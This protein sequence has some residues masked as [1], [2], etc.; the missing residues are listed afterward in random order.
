M[1]PMSQYIYPSQEGNPLEIPKNIAVDLKEAILKKEPLLESMLSIQKEYKSNMKDM[2]LDGRF[3]VAFY[4]LLDDTRVFHNYSKELFENAQDIEIFS[5]ETKIFE[6]LKKSEKESIDIEILTAEFLKELKTEKKEKGILNKRLAELHAQKVIVESTEKKIE[7]VIRKRRRDDQILAHETGP[8]VRINPS[9]LTKL[10]LLMITALILPGS[11]AKREVPTITLHEKEEKKRDLVRDTLSKIEDRLNPQKII[12]TPKP[13]NELLPDDAEVIIIPKDVKLP[14]KKEGDRSSHEEKKRPVIK[15]KKRTEPEKKTE[16]A[17]KEVIKKSME[18][19]LAF[20]PLLMQSGIYNSEFIENLAKQFEK[21]N[22]EIFEEAMKDMIREG[23]ISVEQM[24]EIK[25]QMEKSAP[26][27]AQNVRKKMKQLIV[28]AEPELSSQQIK[29]A[30]EKYKR[31]LK[32]LYTELSFLSEKEKIEVIEKILTGI[33]KKKN[34]GLSEAFFYAQL[35]EE[36]VYFKHYHNMSQVVYS[37]LSKAHVDIPVTNSL[38]KLP[39]VWRNKKGD[40]HFLSEK[41]GENIA[42]GDGIIVRPGKKQQ[43]NDYRREDDRVKPSFVLPEGMEVS[44]ISYF[45]KQKDGHVAGI[46]EAKV[47]SKKFW[48]NNVIE[49]TGIFY[50]EHVIFDI[51]SVSKKKVDI[52]YITYLERLDSGDIVANVV[53]KRDLDTI[54]NKEGMITNISYDLL[55]NNIL[56]DQL[57]FSGSSKPVEVHFS[58]LVVTEDKKH[59]YAILRSITSAKTD[60]KMGIYVL[61]EKRTVTSVKVDGKEM[62]IK[63]LN[64]LWV[65]KEKML[66]AYLEDRTVLLSLP[67]LRVQDTV[68]SGKGFLPIDMIYLQSSTWSKEGKLLMKAGGRLGIYSLKSMEFQDTFIQDG[69]KIIFKALKEKDS[70][71]GLSYITVDAEIDGKKVYGVYSLYFE[72]FIPLNED[73]HTG[74]TH[75]GIYFFSSPGKIVNLITGVEIKEI[76]SEGRVIF[77]LGKDITHYGPA[78]GGERFLISDKKKNQ[79]QF[80]VIDTDGEVHV[81]FDSTLP[82]FDSKKGEFK[83]LKF[84]EIESGYQNNVY[85]SVRAITVADGKEVDGIYDTENKI[86][87]HNVR[88]GDKLLEIDG[89]Y[90]SL[91]QGYFYRGVGYKITLTLDEHPEIEERG[92]K[93]KRVD[94]TIQNGIL[95]ESGKESELPEALYEPVSNLKRHISPTDPLFS[96]ITDVFPSEKEEKYKNDILYYIAH[97][98]SYFHN[99]RLDDV[100]SLTRRLSETAKAELFDDLLHKDSVFSNKYF[101]SELFERERELQLKNIFLNNRAKTSLSWEEF[102]KLGKEQKAFSFLL[103]TKVREW[104]QRL[105]SFS[106]KNKI[107]LLQSALMKWHEDKKKEKDW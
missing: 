94:V 92:H 71:D 25:S 38:E 61:P 24:K 51:E 106:L 104:E 80:L 100:Y 7:N 42:R 68:K 105:L 79:I 26:K 37:V 17:G 53:P 22:P 48:N 65:G 43:I 21:T 36:L 18:N 34:V 81:L 56:I 74:N 58:E 9:I 78:E 5:L 75:M 76:V 83:F 59:A 30:V 45:E 85:V 35:Y 50:D 8:N 57:V 55:V 70:N 60:E 67:D 102:L 103:D 20:I 32:G 107:Q 64:E 12:P 82:F 99:Q 15:Q 95:V 40:W 3:K 52:E 28:A 69:K 73:L 19:A 14:P 29:D 2:P 93:V 41:G 101:F 44:S 47:T 33:D 91:G 6:F 77:L 23:K 62:N 46:V 87:I 97:G 31:S 54:G 89:E 11:V 10:F 27:F 72:K 96:K 13:K 98:E 84:K 90:V 16:Q 4:K 1:C 63:K 49:K 86:F 88:V 39:G 66:I